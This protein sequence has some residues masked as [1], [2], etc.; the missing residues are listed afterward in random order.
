MLEV[1]NLAYIQQRAYPD[2]T[3]TYRIRVRIKGMPDKSATFSKKAQAKAWGQKMEAEVRNG[4]YF[5]R[6]EDK[7]R[8]FAEFIDRYIENELP[9]KPKS[10]KKQKMQLLWWKKHFSPYF[11]CH[12]TPAMIAE[13]RDKLLSECTPKGNKRTSSTTNRSLAA[14]SHAFTIAVKEW[15]WLHE[16]IVLKIKRPKEG[17]PRERFLEADE[18]SSLLEECRKSKSPHLYAIVYFA[19]STGARKGGILSLKWHDIDFA[20]SKVTFK[21]T[22]NGETRTVALTQHAA[23]CLMKEKNKRVTLSEYVFPVFDGKKPA[24]IKTAWE[25][26][27]E[28]AGLKIC[29]HTLRHTA[30]SH[31]AM[32]GAS[33]LEIAAI[34]GHKSLSMV[35]RYSH[36][37]TSSTACVLNKMNQQ[38]LGGYA[39]G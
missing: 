32:N 27:I 20:R 28:K 14:L 24:D 18:I 37:S 35:K 1:L 12:V 22:K 2:G 10:F 9:K 3:T 21:D 8:T 4:R 31:L 33:T 26:A 38:I 23:D 17:K 25:K 30:A 5:S 15:G 16:N 19:I 34:L 6:Q 29:F 11:L 39:N 7:E 36:L 13:N